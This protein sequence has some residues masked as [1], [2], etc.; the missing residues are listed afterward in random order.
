[1]PPAAKSGGMT[2][3][4]ARQVINVL[5]AGVDP[6]TGEVQPEG[7][8]LNNPHVIRALFIAS[9]ALELQAGT[10]AKPQPKAA[11]PAD[12]P[13]NAGT[14]WNDEEASR[15]AAAFDA[16]ADVAQLARDH[17][18]STGSIHSRLI[19]LGRA[20]HDRP[21]RRCGRVPAWLAWPMV[22]ARHRQGRRQS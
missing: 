1:M 12:K 9:R 22:A 4:E 16:G 6:E 2:P 21:A 15:L 18:C 10:S 3:T 7:S 20:R 11:K 14:A 19:R 5:A 13:T 8:P 17:Q